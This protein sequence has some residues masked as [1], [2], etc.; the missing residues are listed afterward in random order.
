MIGYDS[1][2]ASDG[3]LRT[4]EQ[5]RKLLLTAGIILAVVGGSAALATMAAWSGTA[6]VTAAAAAPDYWTG[7]TLG[8]RCK[9]ST[10]LVNVIAQPANPELTP[11]LTFPPQGWLVM[12][13]NPTQADGIHP[14]AE[15]QPLIVDQVRPWV[16][17]WLSAF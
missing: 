3:L 8:V 16:E 6:S 7:A 17:D 2:E 1:N 10:T 12:E 13:I 9:A 14:K 4:R 5:P 15:A 11:C